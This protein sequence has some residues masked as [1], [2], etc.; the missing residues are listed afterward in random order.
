VYQTAIQNGELGVSILQTQTDYIAHD[1]S[2]HAPVY[3]VAHSKIYRNDDGSDEQNTSI[4]Y[5]WYTSS[6]LMKTMAVTRPH[7]FL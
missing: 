1:D 6:Y 3:L 4:D 2:V 7:D 5:T